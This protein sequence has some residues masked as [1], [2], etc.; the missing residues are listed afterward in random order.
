M[1]PLP[2]V[3]RGERHFGLAPQTE[4]NAISYS[5]RRACAGEAGRNRLVHR[6]DSLRWGCDLAAL[7]KVP[8]L[9]V[10]VG[11]FLLNANA[12]REVFL[13]ARDERRLANAGDD[14]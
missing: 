4:A 11:I 10:G 6:M 14:D 5:C 2:D 7:D 13:T 8:D 9:T 12:A 3:S 1:Q